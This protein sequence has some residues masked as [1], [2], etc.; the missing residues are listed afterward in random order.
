MKRKA[1][2]IDLEM[3][4]QYQARDFLKKNP[5]GPLELWKKSDVVT[6]LVAEATTDAALVCR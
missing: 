2:S 1:N 4:Y 5:F 3:Q 6:N